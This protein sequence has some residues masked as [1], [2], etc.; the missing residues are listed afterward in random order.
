MILIFLTI[1]KQ[2]WVGLMEGDV[3]GD[4]DGDV[5]G[6][7]EGDVLGLADGDVLGFLVGLVDGDV[8]G[9]IDGLTDGLVEGDVDGD[10]LGLLEGL[11]DGLVVGELVMHAGFSTKFST[12]DVTPVV[13]PRVLDTIVESSARRRLTVAPDRFA[14]QL[15]LVA[16]SEGLI[17]Q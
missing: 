6:L 13:S 16:S 12:T 15:P 11:V 7:I 10:V 8:L 5:E 9:L 2:V 3:D 4:V 14:R 17:P 1:L